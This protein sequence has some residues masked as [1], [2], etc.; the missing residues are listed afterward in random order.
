MGK[1]TVENCGQHATCTFARDCFNKEY[2]KPQRECPIDVVKAIHEAGKGMAALADERVKLP[3]LPDLDKKMLITFAE[4]ITEIL[5]IHAPSK[6]ARTVK[7]S[8]DIC[9]YCKYEHSSW[10]YLRDKLGRLG[11]LTH[12]GNRPVLDADKWD[13]RPLEKKT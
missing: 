3:L 6:P 9:E 8:K 5:R 7:G 12:D 1:V 11:L 2:C 13:A 4:T 10:S